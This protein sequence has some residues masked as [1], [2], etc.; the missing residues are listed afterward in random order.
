MNSVWKTIDLRKRIPLLCAVLFGI[1]FCILLVRMMTGKPYKPF[2]NDAAAYS[3]GAKNIS[4]LGLYSFDGISPTDEREPGYSFFLA[5]IYLLFGQENLPAISIIQA[6][7]YLLIVLLFIRELRKTQHS[8]VSDVTCVFLLLSPAIFRIVMTPFRESITLSLFLLFAA[9]FLS[10]VQRPSWTRSLGMG[11]A[12]ACLIL[13]FAPLLLFPICLIPVFIIQ[14]LPKRFL[15]PVLFIPLLAASFWTIRNHSALGRY[16]F[17]DP[18]HSASLLNTRALQ[19]QTFKPG[20]SLQCLWNE[21]ITRNMKAQKPYCYV[22]FVKKNDDTTRQTR[23]ENEGILLHALPK[24]AWVAL[25]GVIEYHLPYVGGWGHFYNIAEALVTLLLSIGVLLSLRHIWKPFF[26]IFLLAMIYNIAIS[27]VLIGLPRF[28]MV[29]FFTYA[30]L[31]GVGYGRY[32]AQWRRKRD[33]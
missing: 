24:F 4:E 29:T 32:I 17:I 21:Y 8:S 7:I 13:T 22:Q 27:A 6:G 14:R 31:A 20:D 3:A 9:F 10:F 33:E 30:V 15:L 12:M 16:E 25:F 2:D 26:A 28:R 11:A 1:I 18:F 23:R 19:V 5:P